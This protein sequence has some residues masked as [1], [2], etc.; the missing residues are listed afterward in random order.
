MRYAVA[1]VALFALTPDLAWAQGRDS[2]SSPLPSGVTT[3]MLALARLQRESAVRVHVPGRGWLSGSVVRNGADSLV[4]GAEDGPE[5]AIPTAAIDSVFVRH[6]HTSL[7]ATA[8]AL[9]GLIAG[10]AVANGAKCGFL[11]FGCALGPPMGGFAIGAVVG[12]ALGA[13]TFSWE[14]RLPAAS[15]DSTAP[16]DAH[17][18]LTGR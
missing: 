12:A 3:Q 18:P 10:M 11:D 1:L 2:L 15:A 14:R 6:G 17:N 4:L 9:V 8:G 7:G 5:H 16:P 13:G